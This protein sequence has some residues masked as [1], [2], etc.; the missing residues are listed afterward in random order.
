MK[1]VDVARE[2]SGSPDVNIMGACLGGMTSAIA[3]A[4]L[5]ARGRKYRDGTLMVTLLEHLGRTGPLPRGAQ[6]LAVARKVSERAGG[7]GVRLAG[8]ASM[9]SWLRRTIWCGTTG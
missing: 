2:I 5:P 8:I 1:A 6:T 3:Q 9:F 7:D 4:R